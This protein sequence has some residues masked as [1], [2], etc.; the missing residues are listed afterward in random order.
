MAFYSMLGMVMVA[1]LSRLP[2]VFVIHILGKK[3][4][5]GGIARAA[6]GGVV[7]DVCNHGILMV[8]RKLYERGVSLGQMMAFLIASPWNSFSLLLI[9]IALAGFWVGAYVYAFV[10]GDCHSIGVDF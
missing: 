4:G 2:H 9:L 8:A 7:L 6:V 3:A 5:A 10:Y 1:L